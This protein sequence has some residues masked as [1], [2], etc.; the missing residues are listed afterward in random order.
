MGSEAVLGAF[1]F[2]LVKCRE[3]LG[4]ILWA[5]SSTH[6]TKKVWNSVHTYTAPSLPHARTFSIAQ[7]T[8]SHSHTVHKALLILRDETSRLSSLVCILDS[9][10]GSSHGS[11]RLGNDMSHQEWFAAVVKIASHFRFLCNVHFLQ[12]FSLIKCIRNLGV[13]NR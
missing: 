10:L 1:N 2:K 13:E 3:G 9:N 4:G 7:L 6:N 8:D 12:K 11:Q 5:L